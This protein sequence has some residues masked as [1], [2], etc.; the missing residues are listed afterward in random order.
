MVNRV[1]CNPT[2]VVHEEQKG[3]LPEIQRIEIY[4]K[5]QKNIQQ[6]VVAARA[7]QNEVQQIKLS[8]T[9]ILEGHFSVGYKFGSTGL[10]AVT[11]DGSA[12][13]NQLRKLEGLSN[14]EVSLESNAK[15]VKIWFVT[16]TGN[17]GNV[18]SLWINDTYVVA[19]GKHSE[20]LE[21]IPGVPCEVQLIEISSSTAMSGKFQCS[22][23]GYQTPLI[24]S[25]ASADELLSSFRSLN[26]GEVV[27][28]RE[29]EAEGYAAVLNGI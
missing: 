19:V 4:H 9:S 3:L 5:H 25:T 28:S 17:A 8:G 2:V 7:F 12:L 29:I 13:E 24:S 16:F 22:L 6:V 27:V 11:A 21:A 23:N 15:T 18:P 26:I 14:V 20:V 10:L 1:L